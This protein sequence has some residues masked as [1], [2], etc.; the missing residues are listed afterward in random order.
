MSLALARALFHFLWQGGLVWGLTALGL[1][2][3]R[4]P[5]AR[6]R[7]ACAGLLLCLVL[8]MLTFAQS[9]RTP[10]PS[11]PV[12]QLPDAAAVQ[13]LRVSPAPEPWHRRLEEPLHLERTLR[14][15]APYVLA[16][17]MA[18][19]L[20][21]AVR[22]GLGL[23]WIR[24]ARRRGEPFQDAFWTGRLADLAARCGLRRPVSLR[25]FDGGEGPF[26]IGTFRPLILLPASL[27]SGMPPALVEAL[28]AH[29]L[30]H[31]RR[32][33]YLVNLLQSAVEILLFYH[34]AVWWISRRI[35]IE[36]EQ[37]C[38]DLAA[39]MLDEPRRLALALH[40][41][42]R[43]QLTTR[44]AVP[45][46][47][48]GNLMQRIRRLLHPEP[49]PQGIRVLLLTCAFA[50]FCLAAGY[51]AQERPTLPKPPV[52]PQRVQ[53]KR[54]MVFSYSTVQDRDPALSYGLIRKG[55]EDMV[56]SGSTKR[57]AEIRALRDR[58]E[59]ALWFREKGVSYLV[60]DPALLAEALVAYKPVEEASHRLEILGE[61]MEGVGKGTEA[62]A[63][64]MEALA[65][66]QEEVARRMEAVAREEEK[67]QRELFKLERRRDKAKV[68]DLARLDAEVKALE[69]RLE[70]AEKPMK[71]LDVEMEK[72]EAPMKA[73]E[74]R[75][76]ASE[77]PL[78][79]FEEKMKPVEAELDQ[80][81]AAFEKTLQALLR[82]AQAQGAVKRVK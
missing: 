37:A 22:T 55:R 78:Q 4:R 54:D 72:L 68:A 74:T 36:R 45:A 14:L 7:V 61:Q 39:G 1:Q 28:L 25:L 18:G 38:D 70:A 66:Q 5:A 67:L 58:G 53:P 15:G 50:G 24:R 64:E 69:A 73:L 32:F 35:R 43:F 34:P 65:R 41:L 77:K 52:P 44:A 46:A 82:K 56:F 49:R 71:A 8:P 31:I 27:L 21:L 20:V 81:Q 30:A 40:E 13:P 6:Y 47:S 17:W 12:R 48:G 80:A 11:T 26:T 57:L 79:A 2:A 76:E 9:L 3:F 10:A 19:A 51:A 16:L 29:E 23:H 60:Q 33:D 42:D 63:R 75:M 59:D 62:V